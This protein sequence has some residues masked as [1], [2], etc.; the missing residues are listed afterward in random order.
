MASRNAYYVLV[1][2]LVNTTMP[3]NNFNFRNSY[4][5]MGKYDNKESYISEFS[6]KFL[7]FRAYS[8][9]YE[10]YNKIVSL[11]PLYSISENTLYVVL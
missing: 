7:I 6:E 2:S 5:F 10:N 3:A 11:Y 8:Q 9:G 4:Q 1:R